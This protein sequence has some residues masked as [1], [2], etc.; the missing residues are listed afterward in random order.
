MAR[1][2]AK[3]GENEANRVAIKF[4]TARSVRELLDAA[5]EKYGA[6]D[7]DEADLES[8]VLELV[9]AEEVR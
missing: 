1:T 4:E 8:E 9:T 2:I 3:L 7:W 5:R 6:D